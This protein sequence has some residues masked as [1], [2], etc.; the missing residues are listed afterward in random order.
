MTDLGPEWVPDEYGV[1]HREAGRVVLFDPRGRLLLA[2]GHD[3]H[4]PDRHWWFTIGGG[5]TA[6][7]TPR[8]GASRELRE[9]TG[10]SVLPSQ[11]V[12]PVLY[13]R[14]EFDFLNVTARQDE[15]FFV[16]HTARVALDRAG[17]TDLER[18]VVDGQK[19]WD[20][21]ELEVESQR[22]QV[23]PRDLVPL[24]RS[25]RQGWDGTTLTVHE[26]RDPSS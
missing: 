4:Q 6:G 12:G 17:W 20:L 22:V 23:Y 9:E 3:L 5:L 15:W 18:E 16:A 11:M 25:W 8:E 14:A 19:W 21:D 7:E 2:I 26:G 24:A 10:I 13:R 1:P